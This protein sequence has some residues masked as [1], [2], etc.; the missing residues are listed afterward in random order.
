M[1][2]AVRMADIAKRLG[3]ST[4]TV[5]KA[6]ADQKG[7]SEEMRSRIKA[8]AEELGYRAP[9]SIRNEIR[10]R[11]YNMGVLVAET[12]IEK[13]ATFYWELYQKI[14][15]SAGREHCFVI[16]EVLENSM[17]N[18]L[19]EPKLLKEDKIDG[20]M[21]LGRI[22]TE[23]L[24]M[25][26]KRHSIPLVYMDFYDKEAKADCVISNS[27]Y[28]A[29]HIT[30][31][32]FEMGHR[33]IGFVGTLL[34]TESITDRFL[35]YQKALMEHGQKV[36]EDWVIPD[37][38]Q[39][40]YLYDQIPLPKEMPTAFVCNSDLTAS[41]MIRNLQDAGFRVP[42]DISIVGYDDWLHPGLCDIGITTYSV[43]M[44]TMARIGMR[45]MMDRVSGRDESGGMQVVEGDLVIRDSVRRI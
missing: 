35:G 33:R 19:E 7:V 25:I 39:H 38:D 24:Q 17:E 37:R 5:S 3:V 10:Q 15:T 11:S 21:I 44:N 2:K 43:D 36:R 8:L 14:N 30:N 1:A 27:F 29:Y 31:Y 18:E 13:Y 41:R 28:G 4:V 32:L 45:L 40:I 34:A 20:L 42:E 26:K 6:L 9:S 16:L 22:R 12:Y 23:Y